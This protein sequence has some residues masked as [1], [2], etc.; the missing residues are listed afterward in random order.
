MRTTRVMLIALAFLMFLPSIQAQN[1]PAQEV[2]PT[3]LPL[4]IQVL[5]TEYSGTQ[6]LS[7]LPYTIYI[8]T[9][10]RG[11]RNDANLRFGVKVPITTSEQS[12]TPTQITYQDVGTD[13]DCG[14]FPTDGGAFILDFTV[15]RTS[16][17]TRGANGEESEW[18]PG[19]DAPSPKP[20]LRN[21][22]DSFHLIMRDGAT[23]E[24]TSAVD[25]VTGH[26]F[27]IE[28]TLNVLK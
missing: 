20:L 22:R 6:K 18:K 4:K 5:L 14:A 7:S 27:K 10:R 16:V 23:M 24:G 8:V 9:D 17:V 13:I 1:K 2:P 21:F 28:V 12:G 19:T 11:N 15:A 25:P 3:P 26:V